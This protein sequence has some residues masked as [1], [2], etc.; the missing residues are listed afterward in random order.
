MGS[1]R[2]VRHEGIIGRA[3]PGTACH[4]GGRRRDFPR[5]ARL[6]VQAMKGAINQLKVTRLGFG[7]ELMDLS[8]RLLDMIK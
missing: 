1:E 5:L 6:P 8:S 2:D 7:V 4:W 3:R